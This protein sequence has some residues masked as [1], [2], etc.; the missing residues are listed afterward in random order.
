MNNRNTQA[1]D[2][3]GRFVMA[4]G[5]WVD[6][7]TLGLIGI[8]GIYMTAMALVS[9]TFLTVDTL[10]SQSRFVALYVLVALSQAICLV[11]RGLNL[12]IGGVGSLVTV[13]LGLCVDPAFGGLPVWLGAL[14]A[15]LIGPA[16]G[17]LHGYVITRFKIDCFLVTLSMMF[18][19][20]GLRSGISGGESYK[21]PESFWLLGQGSFGSVLPYM[22][23]LVLLILV[24]IS[25]MFNSTVF[26]RRMLATGSNPDAARLSGI[27][28]D[29]MIV[30]THILSG[31]FAA[32]AAILWASWNGNAAPQTGDD[33]M[34]I[35]FAVAI[36]GGT[37]LSGSLISGCGLFVSAIIFKLLQHSLV[38]LKVN[39]Q[40]SN[41]VLG[42]L[43]LLIVLSDRVRKSLA[44]RPAPV[45]K[46]LPTGQKSGDLI[47][48]SVPQENPHDG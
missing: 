16:L 28:T 8:A 45:P 34:I 17:I 44:E 3:G 10:F 20:I 30:W 27:N 23:V 19:Y 42:G 13:V 12:T 22:V 6:D 2:E 48:H 33:W 26:G 39:D 18:V 32:L 7:R 36:I 29:R 40:Y 25:Y 9:P 47:Q 11:T 21:I 15:F 1:E 31:G 35:S 37:G 14:L 4:K 43:I 41:T 24:A 46:A 38:I 5:S